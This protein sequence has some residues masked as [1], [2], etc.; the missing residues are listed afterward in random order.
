MALSA[1]AGVFTLNTTTGNQAITGVGFQPDVVL[2]IP[3]NLTADGIQAHARVGF[4]A[5]SSS[6]A[7]GAI[8]ANDED[9]VE[10][11]D[12]T[13]Y[14]T[15]AEVLNQLAL[16]E[17][18]ILYEADL[19]SLDSDGFT[20]NISTAPASGV[21]VAYLALGGVDLTNA[22]VGN[23]AA[24]TTNGNQAVT[25]VG[26]QPD[27]LILFT[28]GFSNNFPAAENSVVYTVGFTD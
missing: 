20:I 14:H 7:R 6:T 10:P 24:T 21:K 13:R 1:K 26:F 15:D 9:G 28:A 8:S 5:G 16:G 11:S 3:S 12:S 27:A 17:Q 18:T 25:G 2:F 23:F 4:G 19:V 22:K